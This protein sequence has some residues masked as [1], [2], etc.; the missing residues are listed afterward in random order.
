MIRN[1]N[2]LMKYLANN[3]PQPCQRR[4]V[5]AGRVEN[6]GLFY[7]EPHKLVVKITSKH[8]KVWYVVIL[9]HICVEKPKPYVIDKVPW[10]KWRGSYGMLPS[11]LLNGD[12]PEIYE[13][14]RDAKTQ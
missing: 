7:M 11:L 9:H 2:D 12:Y 13:E 4:A 6:L 5:E 10:E 14:K 3:A 1:R 8:N